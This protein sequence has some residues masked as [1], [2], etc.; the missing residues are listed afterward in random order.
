MLSGTTPCVFVRVRSLAS[1]SQ[2]FFIHRLWCSF[3]VTCASIHTPSQHVPC[4]LN[5]MNLSPTCIVIVSLGQRCCLWPRL[6]MNSAPC[7]FAVSNCSPCLL[8][9]SMLLAAHLSSIVMTSLASFRVPT[10][11]GSS[12]PDSHSAADTYS[13]THLFSPEV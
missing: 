4:C 9:H 10:E 13:S 2:A 1:P 8:A 12:M 11:P 6:R 5:P 3:S 7:L